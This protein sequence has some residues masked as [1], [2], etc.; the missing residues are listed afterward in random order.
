MLAIKNLNYGSFLPIR[1]F[2]YSEGKKAVFRR[3]IDIK[4]LHRMK[5]NQ[6]KICMITAYDQIQGK[7][8]DKA[9]IHCVLVGDSLA[10]VLLGMQRTA[11]VSIKTM[12][13][14]TK[15]AVAGIKNAM[16]VG[17]MPFGSYLTS[18]KALKNASL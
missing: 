9:G 16:V 1:R 8:A 18:D 15:A 11:E 7:I 5:E 12:L 4:S 2:L 14:H 17:D 6:K 3:P 10:N 13:H